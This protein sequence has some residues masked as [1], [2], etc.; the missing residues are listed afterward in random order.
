MHGMMAD[1]STTTTVQ[2]IVSQI[3]MMTSVQKY[4]RFGKT[5][6]CG[7]PTEEMLSTEN[8]WSILN[9]KLKVRRILLEPIEDDLDLPSVRWDVVENVFS[10]LLA[11]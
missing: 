2:K 5:F 8:D 4:F 1:F 10:S 6:S 7:I 9:S 3:T 11:N